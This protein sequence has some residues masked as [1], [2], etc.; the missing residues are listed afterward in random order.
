METNLIETTLP[1]DYCKK[2]ELYGLTGL[3]LQTKKE[4]W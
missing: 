1:L 4:P 3:N 2:K